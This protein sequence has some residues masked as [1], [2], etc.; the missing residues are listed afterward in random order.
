MSACGCVVGEL[1]YVVAAWGLVMGLWRCDVECRRD[2]GVLDE[3]WS[4]CVAMFCV[5]GC[6]LVVG[7]CGAGASVIVVKWKSDI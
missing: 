6:V 7:R 4:A 2:G 5:R 3:V 1:C